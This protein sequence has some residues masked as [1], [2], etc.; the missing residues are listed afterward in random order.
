MRV[1]LLICD[2]VDESLFDA[3]G[4][5]YDALYTTFFGKADPTLEVIPYDV[6]NGVFPADP[7]ECDGWVITGSRYDAFDDTPWIEELR[8]FVRKI[9]EHEA[10][11]AGICFGHQIIAEALGGKVE[12]AGEWKVG[13]QVLKMAPQPWFAGGELAISA[14]HKD[15][16][17]KVPDGAEVIAEGSTA[18]IPAFRIGTNILAIQDHPE[19]EAPF[20]EAL[21]NARGPLF[22]DDQA[23]DA[24]ARL[25]DVPTDQRLVGSW[26][27]D[28]LRDNR[29]EPITV[30]SVQVGEGAVL[31]VGTREV[32]TGIHKNPVAGVVVGPNG[33]DGDV[34]AD[35]ERHGGPDQAV[36]VYAREDYQW[37][38]GQLNKSLPPGSFGENITISHAGTSPVRVGDRLL[39]GEVVLE[40]TAPRIPCSVFAAVMSEP[41]WI[42]RFNEARRPGFYCRVIADGRIEPGDVVAWM[43]AN[44]GNVS[45]VEVVDCHLDRTTPEAQVRRVLEAPIAERSRRTYEARLVRMEDGT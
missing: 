28:F 41:N 12:R 7:G 1:G 3:A 11:L 29:A 45:V 42:D 14:M 13:P 24:L 38:E 39:I 34:V 20:M 30:E 15:V 19:Y 21:I 4:G 10:R 5:D 8:A 25:R 43:G 16:V 26:I 6:I 2:H 31:A 9:H 17:T 33:V 27:V 44:R 35:T 37:W 18:A 22:G 36:Y 40:V 32:E 23:E